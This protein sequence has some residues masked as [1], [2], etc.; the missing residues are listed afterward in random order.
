MEA[1][2][3]VEVFCEVIGFGDTV[4]VKQES[5]SRREDHFVGGEVSGEEDTD[6]RSTGGMEEGGGGM[7][8]DEKGRVVPGT[9]IAK[10]SIRKSE[11]RTEERDEHTGRIIGSEFAIEEF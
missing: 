4:C 7:G 8:R 10:Q 11:S 9:G 3:A 1:V 6:R 5:D 2:F